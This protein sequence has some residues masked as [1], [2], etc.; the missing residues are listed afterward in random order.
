M[1]ANEKVSV[2]VATLNS[3]EFLAESLQSVL[4]SRKYIREILVIDGGSKDG[5]SAIASQFPLVRFVSGEKLGIAAAYNKG[6][7]EASCEWI[8]F[9][10]SDDT[11]M[12]D[13]LHEQ[14]ELLSKSPELEVIVGMAEFFLHDPAVV[15]ECFRQEL[16]EEPR[17]AYIM[18]T[19][20]VRK[21]VYEK[22]GTYDEALKTAEDVDWFSR[23]RHQGICYG[24]VDRVILRKRVHGSNSSHA[25][26]NNEYLL[27]ALHRAVRRKREE[28]Q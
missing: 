4:A 25:L 11:W 1:T 15:P 9:N 26:S 24:A 8:A 14:F 18:E 28:T 13:R 21:S 12:P 7:E 17:L 27:K 22:I 10:S 6:I 23:V 16:L 2:V 20:L 3:E 19:L 5:T